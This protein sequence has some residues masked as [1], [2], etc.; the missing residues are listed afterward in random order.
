MLDVLDVTSLKHNLP[1]KS[2]RTLGLHG[3]R[4]DYSFGAAYK[5]GDRSRFP[6][7]HRHGSVRIVDAG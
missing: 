3:G 7:S 1:Q 4:I 5:K 2:C 6:F